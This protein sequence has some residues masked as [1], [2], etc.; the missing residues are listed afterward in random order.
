MDLTE[1]FC[2]IDDFCTS[3]NFAQEK[4]LSDGKRKRNRAFTLCLSEIAAILV[5]FHLSNYRNFKHYYLREV[6]GNLR[7]EF[8]NL[9]SYNR[10]VELK[11]SALL[12]MTAFLTR[13]QTGKCSGIS[14][15]DSTILKVCDNRR[16]YSHKVFKNIARRG[17]SSTGWFYGFKLHL[18]VNDKGELLSFLI[19][20]GNVDDRNEKAMLPMTKNIFGKLFGD[21]GYISDR[22]FN[23]LFEHGVQL[24]TKIRSN[25][26]NKFM[27]IMD[28]LLLRKRALIE[29]IN[30]ELKNIC[31]I[32]HTRHRSP[33]NWI[34]NI[35]AGLAAYTFFPKKPSLNL[36][37]ILS[38]P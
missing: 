2:K 15:V 7:K 38:I 28:K 31:Q 19:T 9:V 8:P 37:T 35:I 10:F 24:I 18:I 21:R 6:C 32:Q 36:Q 30:D 22:L 1:L 20:A 17:K 27:P 34:V 4:I 25:M 5:N 33:I 23:I 14:F 12:L 16:I 11:P 29:S 3:N 13:N 26:K